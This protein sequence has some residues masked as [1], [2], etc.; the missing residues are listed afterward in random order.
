MIT[1]EQKQILREQIVYYTA[2]ANAYNTAALYLPANSKT[3]KI[4]WNYQ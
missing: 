4:F 1:N 2:K 3:R